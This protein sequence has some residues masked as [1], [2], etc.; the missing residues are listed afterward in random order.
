M[1]FEILIVIFLLVAAVVLFAT[2]KLS[3]DLVALM[4][5]AAL[6]LSGIIT[7]REGLS[8]FSNTATV[9]VAA[10]FI[11]SAGLFRTGAVN[12]AGALLIRLGRRSIWLVIVTVMLTVGVLSA[13]INNTAAVAIFLPVML[14]VAREMK[15]SASR[16]LMP[17]SFASMFGGVCTLIGSSTNI[18]VSSIAERRGQE[19]LGMFEMLPFGAIIFVSGVVYMLAVGVRLIPERVVGADLAQS[20]RMDEY[21]TDILL[22]DESESIGKPLK[23]APLVRELNIAVLEIFRSGERLALPVPETILRAG[24]TLRVRCDVEKLRALQEQVGVRLKPGMKWR[25]ADLE[26]EEVLLIEIV[27][28]LNSEL[29][30]KTLEDVRFRETYNATVLAI[31]HRGELMREAF[32]ET[33]LRAGD[34]LL[35]EVRRDALAALKN[36]QNIVIVSEE[37]LQDFRKSKI[38]PALLIIIAVVLAA[39]SGTLPIVTAAITGCVLMVL[40]RCITLDEAYKAIEWRIIFLLAG[41]LTL[42]IALEKTGAARLLSDAMISSLGDLGPTAIVSGLFLITMMLTN[43][44]SNNASAALLA[45][46]AIVTAESLSLNPR[47]FLMAVTFAAS[48][49]FMTPIGYQTNTLI[50]GPGGYKFADFLKVGTPLNIIFWLLATF[51]IPYF[52]TF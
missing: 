33:R 10:M 13:F 42:G 46:I 17:L 45:P 4:L 50:Y 27:V 3:V 39:A 26:S 41:V 23:D 22:L 40:T 51:L 11:L 1:T 25:D 15:V 49:S 18:L 28:R 36:N 29:D 31:R 19:P 21:L 30:G 34:A 43:V 8:G 14:G 35:V 7:T 47:P 9:T 20:F 48:L 44:M 2:E 32:A 16:L 38:V 37:G 6:M 12:F 52:W 5:M 24:D